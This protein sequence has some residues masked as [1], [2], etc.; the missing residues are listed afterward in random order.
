MK[1]QILL[2]GLL[3]SCWFV[4]HS[5]ERFYNIYDGWQSYEA[6]CDDSFYYIAGLNPWGSTSV[7]HSLLFQTISLDGTNTGQN[8]ELF[9]DG[10]ISTTATYASDAFVKTSNNLYTVGQLVIANNNYVPY[11][12]KFDFPVT[13]TIYTI[14]YPIIFEEIKTYF[15]SLI[16]RDSSFYALGQSSD[17]S[18]NI[19]M[20]FHKLDTLGNIEFSRNYFASPGFSDIRKPIQIFPTADKGFILTYEEWEE[21]YQQPQYNLNAMLL[22]IDSLGNEQWRRMLGHNDTLN[23]NPFLFNKPDGN[24]FAVWTDPAIVGPFEWSH[25]QDNDSSSV[26][27]AELNTSGYT[28]WKKD[29][30]YDIPEIQVDGGFYI[31]DIYQDSLNNMYLCGWLS[32][33]GRRGFLIKIDSTGTGQWIRYYD[34]YPENPAIYNC[35]TKIY[36]LT[37]TSD[38]GF[39]MAGEYFSPSSEMF[40][41]GIQA[42]LVIKVDECGC[43]E[44]GCNP[45]CYTDIPALQTIHLPELK[46][47]PNPAHNKIWLNSEHN[48]G[49]VKIFAI[50]GANCIE[51]Q[52]QTGKAINIESLPQGMYSIQLHA[53]GKIYVGQFV[54]DFE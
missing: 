7:E 26:W 9:I 30:K 15:T 46:L 41:A 33:I 24:Y 12:A 38:G 2:V 10:Y 27:V 31:H 17:G 32:Y 4:S 5:Q 1:K 48:K 21:N 35:Y 22:K 11:F 50:N 16:Y 8:F 37:P 51:T 54:R 20:S 36:S 19:G 40:P 49:I 25:Y 28:L 18:Y 6:F 3:I 42:S 29:L 13:D 53:G 34:C 39:I 43:L 44:E 23:Y 45:E 47:Y 14:D 52:W